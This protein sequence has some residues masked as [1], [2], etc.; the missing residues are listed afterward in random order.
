[1]TTTASPYPSV[2]TV[3]DRVG[4]IFKATVAI[5][6]LNHSFVSDVD[7]LLVSPSGDSILLMSDVGGT[8]V[9]PMWILPLIAVPV[10]RFRGMHKSQAERLNRLT[11]MV[12]NPS[13]TMCLRLQHHR[14]LSL[15]H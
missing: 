4:E 10:I 15:H 2:I 11:E 13:R 8:E 7:M 5:E 9:L 3:A 6:G 12:V 1:M 14:I